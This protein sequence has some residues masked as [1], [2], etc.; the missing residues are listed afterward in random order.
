MLIEEVKE[1][2]IQLYILKN[3]VYVSFT[4]DPE[5]V[6]TVKLMKKWFWSARLREWSFDLDCLSDFV[7][8]HDVHMLKHNVIIW[9]LHDEVCFKLLN[10]H[11]Q[12]MVI[13][14]AAMPTITYDLENT[15]LCIPPENMPELEQFIKDNDE[16]GLLRVMAPRIPIK[17]KL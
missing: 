7:G 10:G 14:M 3:R 5:V 2:K 11:D 6:K 1:D 4:Y 13:L 12:D 15:V 8:L 16:I 9:K 17:R